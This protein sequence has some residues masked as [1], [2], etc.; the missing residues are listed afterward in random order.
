M[1]QRYVYFVSFSPFL[2]KDNPCVKKSQWRLGPCSEPFAT[3]E[4]RIKQ[5]LLVKIFFVCLFFIPRKG[6]SSR[7][8]RELELTWQ[9]IGTDLL[10][11]KKCLTFA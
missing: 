2:R 1:E 5:S 7:K 8:R 3:K 9:V 10:S 6:I 11:L 4:R